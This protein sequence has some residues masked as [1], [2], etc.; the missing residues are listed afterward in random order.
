MSQ[1]NIFG[2]NKFTK[3]FLKG[4]YG[5]ILVRINAHGNQLPN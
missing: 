4:N 1:I 5:N 2:S 3:E